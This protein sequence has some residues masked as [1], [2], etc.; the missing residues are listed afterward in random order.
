M[1][2]MINTPDNYLPPSLDEMREGA[3]KNNIA[4]FSPD[5]ILD[6]CKKLAGGIPN[7]DADL[8]SRNKQK[9][10][11][12]ICELGNSNTPLKTAFEIL[13]K[14]AM[15]SGKG[16]GS[17]TTLPFC[18]KET[19]ENIKEIDQN[20]EDMSEFMMEVL[21][22]PNNPKELIEAVYNDKAIQKML[23]VAKVLDSIRGLESKRIIKFKKDPSGKSVRIRP[24][25]DMSEVSK[26][27][28]IDLYDYK[29]NKKYFAQ[30]VNDRAYSV[31]EKGHTEDKQQLLYCL[32][33]VSGSMRDHAGKIP[34]VCGLILNRGEA[35]AKGDA[36]LYITR[37]AGETYPEV[38]VTTKTVKGIMQQF[39]SYSVYSGGTTNI[40]QAIR[41]AVKSINAKKGEK[42][43]LAIIT[44]GGGAMDITS[45]ELSGITLHAFI[46]EDNKELADLARNSGGIAMEGLID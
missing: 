27:K 7:K 4:M 40:N 28:G 5:F 43:Q 33:D 17:D 1:N 37:F 15:L 31:K 35:V 6:M 22:L 3:T 36:Q 30:N 14:I 8:G 32:I 10:F 34:T 20:I 39:K 23:E 21:D 45:T 13:S 9:V 44:D 11:E 41:D 29:R 2:S 42:P 12:F 18:S 16:C 25:S 38:E 26:L 24:I 46:L 19:A